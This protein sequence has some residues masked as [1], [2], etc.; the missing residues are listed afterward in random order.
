MSHRIEQLESTLQRAI[1]QVLQRR[2]ADP[3]IEGLVSVTRVK[4]TPDRRRARVRVSVLP[5]RSER[6]VLAALEGASGHVQTSIRGLISMRHV[7]HLEFQLDESI[8]KQAAVFGAIQDGLERTGCDPSES[9]GQP[10]GGVL[11]ETK[12]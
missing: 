12:P 11:E 1:S 5:A 6:K 4:V 9:G 2:L 3:R 7:P 10:Q 8:K